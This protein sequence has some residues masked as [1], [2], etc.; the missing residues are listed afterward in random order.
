MRVRRPPRRVLH[1]LRVALQ[2]RPDLVVDLSHLLGG[3]PRGAAAGAGRV[4]PLLQLALPQALP[5][6]HPV[7]LVLTRHT[8]YWTCTLP[9]TRRPATPPQRR[10]PLSALPSSTPPE[11]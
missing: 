5:G 4:P 2:D 10:A 6:T 7:E 8:D 1:P 9:T 3:N 11:A